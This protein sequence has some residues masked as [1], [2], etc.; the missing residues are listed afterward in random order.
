MF[1]FRLKVFYTVAKRLNFTRAAVELYITQP[2]VTKHIRELENYFKSTLIER[3]GNRKIKLT[4]AGEILLDYAEHLLATYKELEFD[5]NAL[6]NNHSGDLRI[7]ASTTV[8]QY[9]LPPILAKFHQRYKDV[10]IGLITGNTEQI[11]QSLL[12]KDIDLAMIEG[13][14]RNPQI[15][16]HEFLQDELVLVSRTNNAV[17]KKEILKPEDLKKYPLLLREP[18]SGT[19]DV[20]ANA[21]H[22]HQIKISDLQIEMRL[23]G[24]ESIKSYL[25]HSNCLAFLSVHAIIKELKAGEVRIIDVE[26]LSIERPFH[27]I[28]FHGQLSSLAEQFARFAKSYNGG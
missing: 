19:L 20:I 22:A 13:I 25:L 4:P 2:A 7:G 9:V 3:S 15:S 16:Y 12:N 26:G 11:E 18:G 14:S 27:L 8:A 23:G 17:F 6:V 1:D 24:T 21:L 28:Q 5:M 10:K